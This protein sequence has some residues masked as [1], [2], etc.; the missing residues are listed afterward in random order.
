[1]NKFYPISFHHTLI[2]H[3]P[4]NLIFLFFVLSLV[5]S[6]FLP[7]DPF[8]ILYYILLYVI[9]LV[10]TRP[11][12]LTDFCS[13]IAAQLFLCAMSVFSI[14]RWSSLAVVTCFLS[15]MKAFTERPFEVGESDYISLHQDLNISYWVLNLAWLLFN[16]AYMGVLSSPNYDAAPYFL[17]KRY[18]Y[19]NQ[20][21]WLS[22]NYDLCIS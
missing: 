16:I 4:P 14:V 18:A 8:Y 22:A 1:M 2:T 13:P 10:L 3:I 11:M 7:N 12:H 17:I 15:A 6:C 19:P 9:N 5:I 20:I 21:I